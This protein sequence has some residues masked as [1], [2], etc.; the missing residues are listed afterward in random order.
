MDL[1]VFADHNNVFSELSD[2]FYEK[3]VI[4]PADFERFNVKRGLRNADGTGVMVGLTNI[5]NV[6]GYYIADGERVPKDG[7]LI[8]RGIDLYDFVNGCKKDDRFGFEELVY[9]LLF[10][11]LP[12]PAE[13]DNFCGLISLNRELP[14]DFVEDVIMRAPSPNIMNKMGS[15]VTALYAYD[16]N[17]DDVSVENV[18][19]Q[20][21]QLIAQLPAIMSYAYQVKRRFFYK[22]SMYIHPVKPQQRTA[23]VILNSIRSDRKFTDREAKLLDLCLMIHADHGGGNNSTFTTRCVSSTGTDTYSAIGAGIGSLKGF[24]HGGANIKVTQMT[25]DI[26]ANISNISDEEEVREY[27]RKLVRK[28]A[29]DGSGLIYG[30]GHA[31]YTLSDPRAVLLKESAKEIAEERG[32][33]DDWKLLD[34][35]ERNTPEIFAEEKGSSKI[36]C[37]NVDLYSGLVYRALAIP[38]DLFTPMFAVARVA[39]WCAHRLEEIATS[40]RIMRPAYKNTAGR[41]E[42][43]DL[44]ER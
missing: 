20:S 36:M 2:K 8:Y 12:T 13:L 24:R 21:I 42:Y 17:P 1:S 16:E 15:S 6:E 10:G 19:R 38:E 32:L 5:C 43:H 34:M 7:R 9:L 26:K 41:L 11:T 27:L 35:I 40:G 29:G 14:F 28:Q 39:G 4:A 23:E 33:T 3:N 18:L 44:S 25:D 37:A 22:K 30:M 31:I